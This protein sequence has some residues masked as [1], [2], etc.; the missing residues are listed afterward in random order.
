MDLRHRVRW[1]ERA[2]ELAIALALACAAAQSFA[3]AYPAKPVRVISQAPVGG[4]TDIVTRG[5][6]QQLAQILG[7]PFVIENRSGANGILACEACAKATPDGYTL[8]ALNG[9]SV[10]QNPFMYAKLP[11]DPVRDFAPVVHMG[12]MR[13]AL[14]AHPSLPANTIAQVF[15][16]AKAK[17]GTISWS[18]YGN[19]SDSHLYMEWLKNVRGLHFLN[20]PYKTAGQAFAAVTAG[21]T[22]LAVY[23]AGTPVQQA[24]PDRLKVLA[25]IGEE[26]S[27]FLPGVP[28]FKEVGI[29]LQINNWSGYF[30]PAGTPRAVIQ[31]INIE[32]GKML[33]T[34]EF[35]EKFMT[36]AGLE[37][38]R[39]AGR[40]V[41]EFAAFLKADRAAAEELARVVKIQLE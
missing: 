2:C 1:W 24:K 17:P 10:S 6:A 13:S 32:I 31:Q 30:A 40:P 39:P 23:N 28:T 41:E 37:A 22:Q 29:P 35:R 27:A 15:E 20:V 16:L 26:P 3:Q 8:C 14:L 34:S 4:P 25:V 19:A 18:S 36:S 5:A 33:A 11:Y 38:V 9:A 7:Q 12:L 21:E